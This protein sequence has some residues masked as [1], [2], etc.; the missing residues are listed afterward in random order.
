MTPRHSASAMRHIIGI[1]IS[2]QTVTAMLIGVAEEDG[3]P[4]E[5]VVSSAWTESRSC[6]DEVSRKN[7]AAWVE[8]VR[9]CIAGLKKTA[10]EAELA[11]A[12][13]ARHSPDALPCSRTARS[14]RVS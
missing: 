1:D 6:R 11:E 3:L 10:R 14:I 2:T 5:L 9:E 4:A 12:V 8:L 7:P 13:S